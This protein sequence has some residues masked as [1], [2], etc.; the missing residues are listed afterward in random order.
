MSLTRN[1]ILNSPVIAAVKDDGELMQALSSECE[2][3]FLLYGSLL[4]IGELTDRIHAAGKTAVVH[5]D[6]LDGL[7]NR[8]IAV[9]IL[10]KFSRPDGIIST[11]PAMIR[12][13][14]HAG[15][16]TIQRAFIIDSMSVGNLIAQIG[17]GKPD[18]IEIM[19]GIMPRIIA[20]IGKQTHIPLIAGGLIKY[21]DEV[22][23]ALDAGAVAVSTSSQAVWEM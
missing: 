1:R 10:L 2:V 3:I 11:R 15:L 14:R 20:E 23:S 4:N 21:R 13:A 22:I 6:L 17:T 12:H 5:I 8:E 9:D 19:P 16:L 7:A 18:F